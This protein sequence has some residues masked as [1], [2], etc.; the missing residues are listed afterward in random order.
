MN[1]RVLVLITAGALATP[2]FAAAADPT[3][4][5]IRGGNHPAFVRLVLDRTATPALAE[6]AVDSEIRD[7]TVVVD[8]PR[9]RIGVLGQT[10]LAGVTIKPTQR[11]TTLRLTITA[12]AGRFKYYGDGVLPGRMY[13][14]LWKA[15]PVYPAAAVRSAGCLAFTY[16]SPGT[17]R[18]AARGT[19]RGIFE[20]QFSVVVRNVSGRVV[21]RRAPVMVNGFPNGTWST[22]VNYTVK[23][24]QVGTLEAVDF[25]G[26]VGALCIAQIPAILRPR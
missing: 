9:T 23:K 8:I 21:G 2:G 24:R 25:G 26:R 18:I 3:A 16:A 22:T 1:T 19:A 5:A 7:G 17:G 12:T 20:S 15:R 4:T 6:F 13:M 10:T 11:G 14:D